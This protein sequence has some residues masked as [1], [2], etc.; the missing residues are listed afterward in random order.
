MTEA[1]V[2]HQT[3]TTTPKKTKKVSRVKVVLLL[4]VLMLL[5]AIG[6]MGYLYYQTR[7]E[8][9]LLSTP[10]GQQRISEQEVKQ[11]LDQ[12]GKLTLLPEEEPVMATIID[13]QY[14]AT[15]SAFYQKSE[16][17]DKLVVFPQAK[18]AFIFSPSRNI[19]VN[20]GPL[21]TDADRQVVNVELRNGTND[22]SISEKIKTDL[23]ANGA[24]VTAVGDADNDYAQTRV[25]GM[26]DK[27]PAETLNALATYLNGEVMSELPSGEEK[28]DADIVVIIGN[29]TASL[30]S[31]TPSP[32][33]SPTSSASPSAET[34]E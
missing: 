29:S 23:E 21:I 12:L 15:Q 34:E 24:T 7:Q 30:T 10:Q 26:T 3:T 19:I 4:I 2:T 1:P 27:V 28:S 6:V 25:I 13:A 31:A 8:L 33:A 16:N 18:K 17:G 20:S 5:G 9:L 14:L 11:V 32:S 22:T